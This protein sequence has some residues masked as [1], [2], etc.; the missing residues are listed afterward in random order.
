MPVKCHH[1]CG[2]PALEVGGWMVLH[3]Q[4]STRTSCDTLRV[5]LNILAAAAVAVGTPRGGGGQQRVAPSPLSQTAGRNSP[6]QPRWSAV[7]ASIDSMGSAVTIPTHAE[8]MAAAAAG[9]TGAGAAAAAAATAAAGAAG[10]LAG[11]AAGAAAGAPGYPVLGVAYADPATAQQHMHESRSSSIMVSPFSQMSYSPDPGWGHGGAQ[12]DYPAVQFAATQAPQVAPGMQRLPAPVYYVGAGQAVGAG[13]EGQQPGRE[14]SWPP[15]QGEPLFWLVAIHPG[16]YSLLS[17]HG[18]GIKLATGH[19]FTLASRGD[20]AG[21][22]SNVFICPTACPAATLK[23][24]VLTFE[25][26]LLLL[27]CIGH[28]DGMEQ[29]AADPA[30]VRAHAGLVGHHSL[31]A[32]PSMLGPAA[33]VGPAASMDHPYVAPSPGFHPQDVTAAAGAGAVQ[34]YHGLPAGGF[35]GHPPGF[36]IP[37]AA[38][39]A[40]ALAAAGARGPYGYMH[41]PAAPLHARGSEASFA[42]GLAQPVAAAATAGASAVPSWQGVH[43]SAPSSGRSSVVFATAATLDPAGMATHP[44]SAAASSRPD[45]SLAGGG[46]EAGSQLNSHLGLAPGGVLDAAAAAQALEQ[47]RAA[48]AHYERVLSALTGHAHPPQQL[49][50]AAAEGSAQPDEGSV[51]GIAAHAAQQPAI[52]TEP[53]S[54][55]SSRDGSSMSCAGATLPSMT[56]GAPV[57]GEMVRDSAGLQAAGSSRVT[58]EASES[59]HDEMEVT[60]EESEG[61]QVEISDMSSSGG[62]DEVDMAAP[63]AEEDAAAADTAAAGAFGSRQVT[64]STSGSE[65]GMGDAAAGAGGVREGLTLEEQLEQLE[66]EQQQQ[67]RAE[68]EVG[69][70]EQGEEA[71]AAA[72]SAEAAAAAH[73]MAAHLAYLTRQ[74][75]Y[76]EEWGTEDLPG[77]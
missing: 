74:G 4:A 7:A 25:H 26:Q 21:Q 55:S 65:D 75:S 53:S 35:A 6:G 58:R 12:Q 63:G 41:G 39:V 43:P 72:E 19:S 3:V 32:G 45:S 64:H 1:R 16:T 33:S 66:E 28:A 62:G 67:R 34:V 57:Q 38:A 47:L 24:V 48:A 50:H 13:V 59:I 17:M 20:L 68:V 31:Q 42:G 18:R 40:A 70:P 30:A 51:S 14:Q 9:Q 27:L 37:D 15:G 76:G 56:A 44:H 8:L 73:Q 77:Q 61:I 23:H 71:G 10:L 2:L 60:T 69:A 46:E 29:W 36:A 54:A 49:Q 52:V 5:L 11:A 22:L